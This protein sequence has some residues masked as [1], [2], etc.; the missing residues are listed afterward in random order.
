MGIVR[1]QTSWNTFTLFFGTFIGALNTM[2]LFP[3]FLTQSEYGLTR[4]LAE[5]SLIAGQLAMMGS[6]SLLVKFMPEFRVGNA[7]SG[8]ILSFVIKTS[9]IGFILISALLYFAHDVLIIPYQKNAELFVKYYF[10]LYPM[11]V[12][13][14]INAVLSNY[15]KAI[16]KSIFQ[17]FVKEVILRFAQT[18]L[19]LLLVFNVIDFEGFAYGFVFVHAI[20]GVLIFIYLLKVKELELKNKVVKT[21]HDP[22]TVVRFLKYSFANFLTGIAGNISNR[23]D[24]LMLGAMVGAATSNGNQGLKATAIYAFSSYVVALIEMPARALSN[25]AFSMIAKAWHN[26]DLNEIKLLYHKSAL[27][28]LVS[29]LFLFIL[30]VVNID[31]VVEF[32][33]SISGNDYSTASA[34]VLY[35]GIAKLIHVSNGINGG[36]IVTSKYYYVGTILLIF[37]SVTTFALNYY[38]IPLYGVKGAS[39]AT[40]ITLFLFNLI[41]TMF[42]LFK[43]KIHPFSWHFIGALAIGL[44]AL[45]VYFLPDTNVW[46][47]NLLYKSTVIT[48]IYLPLI[49]F[50]KVSED[51]NNLSN[52]WLK[53]F[54][55][56]KR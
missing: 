44:L 16:Y 40:A 20:T 13:A 55:I 10:L 2:L 30:V 25:I 12:F 41:S 17:L 50:F 15:A 26:N 33:K 27:N 36:I 38:F 48:L 35:L 37:L 54:G 1:K 29:G 53:K 9:F 14:I 22:K 56:L 23:I 24:I 7:N 31:F 32:I 28:Q 39:I 49:Y 4:I 47:V 21:K 45:S 5:V 6:P 11:V 18:F 42:L 34:A 52:K 8:G 51:F 46:Y 43:Y 3:V 19:L